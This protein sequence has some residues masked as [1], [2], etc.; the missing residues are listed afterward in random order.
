MLTAAGHGNCGIVSPGQPVGPLWLA[1]IPGRSRVRCTTVSEALLPRA[2]AGHTNCRPA[3]LPP[4]ATLSVMKGR[5]LS[6]SFQFDTAVSP[7]DGLFAVNLC[8]AMGR[9]ALLR[10]LY[11]LHR[12]RFAGQPGCR[13]WLAP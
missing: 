13:A 8:S 1:I 6:G 4:V 11:N 12:G 5:F 7:A 9:V 2:V 10:V 3:G